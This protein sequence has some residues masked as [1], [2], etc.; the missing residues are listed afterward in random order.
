MYNILIIYE[1]DR[2]FKMITIINAYSDHILFYIRMIYCPSVSISFMCLSILISNLELV[3]S[4]LN[5]EC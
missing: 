5:L 2:N 3:T 1:K 4:G